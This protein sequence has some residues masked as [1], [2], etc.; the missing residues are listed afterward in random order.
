MLRGEFFA[1]VRESP[2]SVVRQKALDGFDQRRQRGFRVG[3]HGQ[4]QFG[5]ALEVLVI[6]LQV[7]IAGA[8][9]D[10]LH[11]L[12][13]DRRRSTMQLIAVR[14]DRAPEIRRFQAEDNVRIANDRARSLR[15][16]QR[17][18]RRKI[19]AR[20]Q[21][22]DGRLQCFGKFDGVFQSIGRARGALE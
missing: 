15:L 3:G 9:A 8:D 10:Q 18:L 6:A 19:H 7:E 21:I 1:A 16:I 5:V 4:V 11:I 13:G 14:M 22:H 2:L 20:G 12:F 17:M